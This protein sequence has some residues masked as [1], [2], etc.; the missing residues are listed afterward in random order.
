[1]LEEVI[2]MILKIIGEK[3]LQFEKKDKSK[4]WF[5]VT[6]EVLSYVKANCKVG[7]SLNAEFSADFSRIT[8]L[9]KQDGQ[10]QKGGKGGYN[11]NYSGGYNGGVACSDERSVYN[12]VA[13]MVAG[14]KPATVVL[15]K[16][17]VKALF[18]QGME[19]IKTKA[20]EAEKPKEETKV[21]DGDEEPKE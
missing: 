9:S 12:A 19:L 11:K 7:D 18:D 6:E 4:K 13:T 3:Q 5:K 17:A 21:K 16:E 20:V 8:K 15:A 1:M 2:D 10:Y 14:M